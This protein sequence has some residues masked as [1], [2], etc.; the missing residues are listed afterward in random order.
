MRFTIRTMSL[1][2]ILGLSALA[3]S[4]C[5]GQF[6][7][8]YENAAPA[9]ARD[10]KSAGV[11]VVLPADLTT[12]DINSF[13]PNYDIVW[14]GE[15]QGERRAQVAAIVEDGARRGVAGLTGRQAVVFT[16]TLRK[17]HSLTPKAYERAPAGTG[18]HSVIFDLT[19]TDAKTGATLVQSER[20]EASIPAVTASERARSGQAAAPLPGDEWRRAISA[21]IDATLRG[22]LGKGPDPRFGFTRLGA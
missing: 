22:W 4:A 13:I 1:A 17:F 9:E 16:L 6:N 20:I 19:V 18:V 5:G 14:H 8:S 7:T 2:V 15:P 10:W 12:S 11:R 3:L 21:H